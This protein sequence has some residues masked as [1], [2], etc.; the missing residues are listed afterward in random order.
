MRLPQG[1]TQHRA[2]VTIG[3]RRGVHADEH[4]LGKVR[5]FADGSCKFRVRKVVDDACVAPMVGAKGVKMTT[6]EATRAL[7]ALLRAKRSALL[8]QHAD[9]RALWSVQPGAALRSALGFRTSLAA[10][11]LELTRASSVTGDP[12]AVGWILIDTRAVVR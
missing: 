12:Y 10:D 3:E 2:G 7:R 6:L 8:V 9:G 11:E 5:G 4:G 1:Y